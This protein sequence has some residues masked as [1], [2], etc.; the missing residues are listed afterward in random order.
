MF[1]EIGKL[2]LKYMELP[3]NVCRNWQAEFKVHGEMPK[4]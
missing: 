2:S 1:A 3:F 4:T